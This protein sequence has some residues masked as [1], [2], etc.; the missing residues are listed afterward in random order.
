VTKPRKFSDLR[1]FFFSRFLFERAAWAVRAD[2]PF[3]S[4]SGDRLADVRG[5]LR[6]RESLRPALIE[7]KM[8]VTV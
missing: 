2:R 4:T 6:G 5:D 1:G 7:I 8:K 3:A